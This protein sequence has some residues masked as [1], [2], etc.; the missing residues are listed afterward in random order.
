MKI[1]R[2]L[3]VG[4]LVSSHSSEWVRMIRKAKKRKE[5]KRSEAGAENGI[6]CCGDIVSRE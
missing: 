4:M 6:V 1:R 3:S 2:V 5:K